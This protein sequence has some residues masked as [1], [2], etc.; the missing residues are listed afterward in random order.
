MINVRV[1]IHR[2][3]YVTIQAEDNQLVSR[4]YL[5]E[6]VG[7]PKFAKKLKLV[8]P[9]GMYYN[10]DDY[11]TINMVLNMSGV[12]VVFDGETKSGLQQPIKIQAYEPLGNIW[13]YFRNVVKKSLV[14]A[15][16]YQTVLLTQPSRWLELAPYRDC[17][18][19]I[20]HR[21]HR[22]ARAV[23]NWRVFTLA[24]IDGLSN[25]QSQSPW[26]AMRRVQSKLLEIDGN[27][28]LE[29]YTS[30]E[31]LISSLKTARNE[32]A[33]DEFTQERMSSI[34]KKMAQAPF[35]IEVKYTIN[36]QKP[37]TSSG[38]LK[39]NK[40]I[41]PQLVPHMV[42][43]P[44]KRVLFIL[45]MQKQTTVTR[46]SIPIDE[47][48]DLVFSHPTTSDMQINKA[49]I[50]GVDE[51]DG[52]NP[53]TP[54]KP[55]D[56]L[57][58]S[59]SRQVIFSDTTDLIIQSV[60]LI[61][62]EMND[63]LTQ[64]IQ[65]GNE[66]SLTPTDEKKLESFV[67]GDLFFAKLNVSES[68]L[69]VDVYKSLFRNY[70]EVLQKLVSG[71]KFTQI[72]ANGQELIPDFRKKVASNLDA[73]FDKKLRKLRSDHKKFE[74]NTALID[75]LT[76]FDIRE[77]AEDKWIEHDTNHN[78]LEQRKNDY[79]DLNIRALNYE[80]VEG[81]NAI[82]IVLRSWPD[83]IFF[84]KLS[85]LMAT[86]QDWIS[87]VELI[88]K[89]SAEEILGE[90]ETTSKNIEDLKKSRVN[91]VRFE[92]YYKRLQFLLSS[93]QKKLTVVDTPEGLQ[94]LVFRW[95]RD[96][97]KQCFIQGS[98]LQQDLVQKSSETDAL[99]ITRA[100]NAT[101]FIE[102]LLWQPHHRSAL[103]YVNS[104][105]DFLF[106]DQEAYTTCYPFGTPTMVCA[107]Q[108][109]DVTGNF[110]HPKD[111]PLKAGT[112]Q[113][114]SYLLGR[115]SS[116]SD[117]KKLADNFFLFKTAE[118]ISKNNQID[119]TNTNLRT[120]INNFEVNVDNSLH[121]RGVIAMMADQRTKNK[122]GIA[123]SLH[124]PESFQRQSIFIKH[125]NFSLSRPIVINFDTEQKD[126]S[127]AH[128]DSFWIRCREQ[129]NR[130]TRMLL[131]I[132]GLM[133][134][135][136]MLTETMYMTISFLQND[137]TRLALGQQNIRSNT[138]D[139][140]IS[141][142]SA[143]KV[144]RA[145]Q[146][147]RQ[148]ALDAAGSRQRRMQQNTSFFNRVLGN[149]QDS[150]ET[151]YDWLETNLTP[152]QT[153]P[154]AE[155]PQYLRSD[156]KSYN[157]II[158]DIHALF[159]IIAIMSKH[160]PKSDQSDNLLSLFF[161]SYRSFQGV[162]TDLSNR[163]SALKSLSIT[164]KRVSDLQ[165]NFG[166]NRKPNFEYR[167]RILNFDNNKLAIFFETHLPDTIHLKSQ[168]IDNLFSTANDKLDMPPLAV[169]IQEVLLGKRKTVE[170][171]PYGDYASEVLEIFEECEI[172]GYRFRNAM[173]DDTFKMPAAVTAF[174]PDR[175]QPFLF[176]E[177]LRPAAR[178]STSLI[179]VKTGFILCQWAIKNMCRQLSVLGTT[180]ERIDSVIHN[181]KS[182]EKQFAVQLIQAGPEKKQEF[183]EELMET[184][185]QNY[186][187]LGIITEKLE[188]YPLQNNPEV[189]Q[190]WRGVK[191]YLPNPLEIV[192]EV[193][194]PEISHWQSSNVSVLGMPWPFRTDD[195]PADRMDK[196]KTSLVKCAIRIQIRRLYFEI[197]T[198]AD[199][200]NVKKELHNLATVIYKSKLMKSGR[201]NPEEMTQLDNNPGDNPVDA[202]QS[203]LNETNAISGTVDTGDFLRYIEDVAS[204]VQKM[205]GRFGFAE[206]DDNDWNQFKANYNPDTTFSEQQGTVV[207]DFNF[208][209]REKPMSLIDFGDSAAFRL[210][211]VKRVFEYEWY[212]NKSDIYSRFVEM[213]LHKPRTRDEL[214]GF[215]G[216]YLFFRY[217][218]I[219]CSDKPCWNSYLKTPQEAFKGESEDGETGIISNCIQSNIQDGLRNRIL[220]RMDC[221]YS[222]M[223]AVSDKARP[224]QKVSDLSLAEQFILNFRFA[225]SKYLLPVVN[226]SVTIKTSAQVLRLS[227]GTGADALYTNSRMKATD[228]SK[229]LDSLLNTMPALVF[230]GYQIL[231]T[232]VGTTNNAVSGRWRFQL[233]DNKNKTLSEEKK[234]L[235]VVFYS[236]NPC[237]QAT[238]QEWC[239]CAALSATQNSV[240][241]SGGS[242]NISE[243]L[244]PSRIRL[245]VLTMPTS[246]R[247]TQPVGSQSR[248]SSLL[249]G[250]GTK[251]PCS[252]DTTQQL[253]LL[254]ALQ[255]VNPVD[256]TDNTW[257]RHGLHKIF[258]PQPS[259]TVGY[260]DPRSLCKAMFSEGGDAFSLL[261]QDDPKPEETDK[262]VDRLQRVLMTVPG[263]DPTCM[264]MLSLSETVSVTQLRDASVIQCCSA[265]LLNQLREADGT[266]FF[267]EPVPSD[268]MWLMRCG[269]RKL[270]PLVPMMQLSLA[271]L[272]GDNM[273]RHLWSAFGAVYPDQSPTERVTYSLVGQ[274]QYST[275]ANNYG[276][277]RAVDFLREL[278]DSADPRDLQPDW[279]ELRY[280]SDRTSIQIKRGA[281]DIEMLA[282]K[283]VKM[284]FVIRTSEVVQ[285]N[286]IETIENELS[287][288]QV[289]QLLWGTDRFGRKGAFDFY[290]PL[291]QPVAGMN[292]DRFAEARPTWLKNSMAEVKADM[293]SKTTKVGSSYLVAKLQDVEQALSFNRE[294]TAAL[295]SVVSASKDLLMRRSPA[296]PQ[297]PEFATEVN[298]RGML[299]ILKEES[300]EFLGN[301]RIAPLLD[302][303]PLEPPTAQASW[304]TVDPR[305]S[306]DSALRR[307]R[308]SINQAALYGCEQPHSRFVS[309]FVLQHRRDTIEAYAQSK[310]PRTRDLALA[311][312]KRA[313]E[314]EQVPLGTDELVAD[315]YGPFPRVLC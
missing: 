53:Q 204:T 246:K 313:A 273:L 72:Y 23:Q 85:H 174:N 168:E 105:S 91:Q 243:M 26:S 112:E 153:T 252:Y 82:L 197:V 314:L 64:L 205:K 231:P 29:S 69:K 311:F 58:Q 220:A 241:S 234:P 300:D 167:E 162:L 159:Y 20:S 248:Q 135:K 21:L 182:Q 117:K 52:T 271:S 188:E 277:A 296:P 304:A 283:F 68:I 121:C 233:S 303:Q 274:Q 124:L 158:S 289:L 109:V 49:Q 235:F 164:E 151:A 138:H 114:Y 272:S 268:G 265:S 89:K 267:A 57:A 216:R 95:V 199:E 110:F 3:F 291:P 192:E 111:N 184:T 249:F 178:Q 75:V 215:V 175:S 66:Q 86:I 193:R 88:S 301:L 308:N 260:P 147:R 140:L 293:S 270:D 126:V 183:F 81:L 106:D 169:S 218:S 186:S 207:K 150:I 107:E 130:Q 219:L 67:V 222:F 239:S 99:D 143:R 36:D 92:Q 122:Q 65:S 212:T 185:M 70:K 163:E 44:K 177:L 206:I 261:P 250:G 166:D 157:S 134:Q 15:E 13:W 96:D 48:Q 56:L 17:P 101:Q 119:A 42:R 120:A 302:L 214:A 144:R 180:F 133:Y 275:R 172:E 171:F 190:Q 10:I 156:N 306:N 118:E 24:I 39:L 54:T 179:S 116:T 100:K 262:T 287:V 208:K 2:S 4:A 217:R 201:A 97:C 84:E 213:Q 310:D 136:S 209:L 139:P 276:C 165:H 1:F 7:I 128:R 279:A 115:I 102:A 73:M 286:V 251:L 40:H 78:A 284:K 298:T 47:K 142:K 278:L 80:N 30:D 228:L 245:V 253:T 154:T 200:F 240:E 28:E 315:S 61:L 145:L 33:E 227:L 16:Y 225:N 148:S 307:I 50:V 55:T 11:T 155:Q 141:A 14:S 127:S 149:I 104:Q 62:L 41:G 237:C 194:E 34:S 87:Q 285:R 232:N 202:C 242:A 189:L 27:I 103:Y 195:W 90:L 254:S 83:P 51:N 288:K 25:V 31:G 187:C 255:D 247:F 282:D 226:A 59:F 19:D 161:E 108:L 98:G 299:S 264:R 8:L 295:L 196:I 37:R 123:H 230:V 94:K 79:E 113:N 170:K 63:V 35:D 173:N 224:F 263:A 297:L 256:A 221:N 244:L 32:I 152:P 281:D 9:N 236:N 181:L 22:M 191:S 294:T 269:D 45:P 132:R 93:L 60:C 198:S 210:G 146:E 280:E 203:I 18:D 259:N 238:L 176:L 71:A 6:Q 129:Y 266:N 160:L 211:D 305:W 76:D 77:S 292:S 257:I 312:Q 223:T 309:E 125:A 38:S 43:I 229:P 74:I 290:N 258:Y 12:D 137:R 5:E 131:F 46:K